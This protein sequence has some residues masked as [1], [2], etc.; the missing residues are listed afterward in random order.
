MRQNKSLKPNK[1]LTDLLERL[2]MME[3]KIQKFRTNIVV[4]ILLKN[5]NLAL[6]IP[7]VKS[8]ISPGDTVP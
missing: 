4:L 7:I 8:Q 3:Q 5:K 2:D 1:I 6:K